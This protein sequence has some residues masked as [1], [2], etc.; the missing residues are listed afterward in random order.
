M[1][2]TEG[3]PMTEYG[4]ANNLRGFRASTLRVRIERR[5]RN[6]VWVRTADLLDAGT[7]LVLDASQVEPEAASTAT[8]P[9]PAA[10]VVLA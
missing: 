5:E 4:I 2:T 10:L 8:V 1:T 3:T 9:H 7:P 6:Y